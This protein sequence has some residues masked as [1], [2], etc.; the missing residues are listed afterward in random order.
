M[1]KLEEAPL[2]STGSL[3][4]KGDGKAAFYGA[5][6]SVEWL[7]TMEEETSSGVSPPDGRNTTVPNLLRDDLEIESISSGLPL[8]VGRIDKDEM[9][10]LA[11]SK[12]P[13]RELASM[14]VNCYYSR[15]GWL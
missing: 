7:M 13:A 12:L 6:S 9:L 15:S 3:V 14:L 10:E 8:F 11:I 5:S 1:K 4:I 2:I